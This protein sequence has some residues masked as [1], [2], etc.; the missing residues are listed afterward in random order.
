MANPR[1][2]FDYRTMEKVGTR[3][4]RPTRPGGWGAVTTSLVDINLGIRIPFRVY[5]RDWDKSSVPSTDRDPLG[6]PWS[7]RPTLE[8]AIIP[9]DRRNAH[10]V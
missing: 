8:S 7:T 9:P 10:S 5:R 1:C 6:K 4:V 2:D 3:H